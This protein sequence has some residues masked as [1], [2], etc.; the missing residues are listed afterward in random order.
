MRVQ[1]GLRR[2]LLLCSRLLLLK[3]LTLLPLLLELI[4]G[5]TNKLWR[6]LE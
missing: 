1:S 6:L 5:Q 3:R 4:L 2:L